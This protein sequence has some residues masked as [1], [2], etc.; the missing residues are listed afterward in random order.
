MK[1]GFSTA[2]ALASSQQIHEPMRV[3][4]CQSCPVASCGTAMAALCWC[5]RKFAS[6]YFS[7]FQKAPRG[8]GM[9]RLDPQDSGGWV[10][11]WAVVQRAVVLG[12]QAAAAGQPELLR[13]VDQLW[14]A[15]MAVHGACECM[16]TT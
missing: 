10:G 15:C 16:R 2:G 11:G 14:T 13:L 5:C 6:T 7:Q 9:M 1:R 12:P 3:S 4:T 8:L